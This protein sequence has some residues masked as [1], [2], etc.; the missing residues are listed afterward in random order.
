MDA[1]NDTPRSQS[2]QTQQT[3]RPACDEST[4]GAKDNRLIQDN[5]DGAQLKQL[6]DTALCFLSTCSNETLL[7]VL[8][9]LMGT[10][11]IVLGRLGL[12]LIGM[13]L[14]VA[15]HASWVGM[16]HSNSSEYTIIGRKQL[17]LSI[18]HKLLNWEEAYPVKADSNT[19]G[20]G[21]DHHRALSVSDVDVLSLG[22]ITA[23]ALHS[24]IGAAMRDYVNSWYEPILPSESTFPN[25]C[26][27]V[28][29]NFITSIASHL[30]R[31]RAA[32]TVLEFLTNSSS[33]VIVFL[34]ELSAA[35]QAAGPDVTAEHAVLQYMESNPESSLS[36]LVAHQQQRRKLQTI[37][38]DLLSRYLDSNAYNCIPV[39]NFLR[40]VLTG[41]AFE[42][43]ITSLS[44]PEFINGWI[45]YLFSEGESE[46][47]NAID[48]GVEGARNHGVAAAKDSEETS[49]PA[50]ISRNGS[51]AEGS[52]SA[53]HTP[54]VPSQV[55]D[56]ADKATR[57]A[58]L[59]AKRLSDMI[60]AQNLPKYIEETTQS[61]IRGEYG[62]RD[63]NIII[64]NAGVECSAEEQLSIAA[65]ESYPS[66]SAQDVQQVQSSELGD[67]V[68]LPS[69]PSMET[70]TGSSLGSNDTTSA[71]SL[72]RASVT[73]DDG[74]D[75][76]DMS[77][78]RTKPTSNYLIQVELHSGRSS[79]W[80]VFKKYADFES[81]HETLVTIARLNQLHF[82]E[83]Y[84]LVPLWKGR[85]HQALARDLER[86]LQEAL[87]L[88]PLAESV[89]MK[90]FLEK[91]RGVDPGG[92]D[93]SG[94]P[95]FVFPG[96]A[97]FEN[98]GKGVLGVLTNGP[99]GVSGGSKAVLDSVSGVFG[100]GLGKKSPVALC[101]DNDDKVAHEDPLKHGPAL[102]K[103]DPK[104][105]D[106]KFSSDT[107]RG[108][109]PSQSLKLCDSDG[110]ASSGESTFLTESS[111]TPV[112]TPESGGNTINKAGD[113]PWSVSASIDRVNQKVDSPSLSEEKQNNDIA[114]MGSRN[115]TETP[116]GRQSNPITGDETRVAVELIFAVINELYLLSSAWNIRRTLLNAAKSY[117]LRPAN[118]SLET[119]RR[120]LQ[121]SMI[122]RHTTDEA[123]GT[124]L[125]KLR[126]NAL[127]T[128]EEL[129]SWPPAMSDA[130]KERQREAARR[131]LIQKGLP[132]A[133]T[134]VMGAVASREALGKVFDSLQ[135]DIVARGLVFSIFLQAMRAIVF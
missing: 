60:A 126:E 105:E 68:T 57:E 34:N 21:E 98:V 79:G 112:P 70:S 9:C 28:L 71:P 131:I 96:Q 109:S 39:R 84:P 44:R 11:Y 18:V 127:P 47:M 95:G 1:P 117:I 111:N 46:I 106:L 30:S 25:A 54:N 108:A 91:D 20:A 132:K 114:L 61:E 42:S 4:R 40:E 128:A 110:F 55:F 17:S 134:G 90:R 103:G 130:E 26:Q 83:S 80:M 77:A 76:R 62:T 3:E 59:E 97:T 135:I 75:S 2:D 116:A 122:D 121:D 43:T 120:L 66:K 50:S 129:N 53:S 69:L 74:C 102:R 63:D 5:T 123:I 23:S 100:G 33:I 93:L 22:P 94:K 14:G 15:L 65:I 19:H 16:D 58:M 124:Y 32:D 92:A 27:A 7:L 89:T 10:T 12:L 51:V 37:S 88:E 8:F 6:L 64:A 118:P 36:S 31:K 45:I 104:E 113:Q 49:R 56:K 125:A 38:D 35:F 48:A 133:I 41:I 81:I 52:I 82:G 87:Q 119:I 78:L 29:T 115:S 67:S 107:K 13:A 24:L 86:Y 85:T 101:A 73:V 99:R 72:F